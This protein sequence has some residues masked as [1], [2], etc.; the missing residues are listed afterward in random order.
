MYFFSQQSGEPYVDES[1]PASP[2]SLYYSGATEAGAAA[3]WLRPN[4]IHVDA[5]HRTPW[6]VFRDPRPSDISQGKDNEEGANGP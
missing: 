1:F 2:R 5:D 6:L 3:R 4:Q